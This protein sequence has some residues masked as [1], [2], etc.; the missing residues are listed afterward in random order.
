MPGNVE[1]G[2]QVER[3]D[4]QGSSRFTGWRRSAR[5]L[6]DEARS[7]PARWISFVVVAVASAAFAVWLLDLSRQHW[8]VADEFDYFSSGQEYLA[9]GREPL[10]FWLLQPHGEHTIVFTK[11]WFWILPDFVGYGHYEFYLLPSVLAHLVVVA[12][13]YRLTWI[14]TASRVLATGTALVSLAMGAGV[15]TLTYAGQ[16][17]YVGSVAAGLVVVLLAVQSSGRRALVALIALS[18]LGTLNGT[19][20]VFFAV[21]ASIVY[22]RRR[23]WPEAFAVA[24]IAVGWELTSRLVWAPHDPYQAQGLVQI[25][26]EGPAFAYAILDQAISQTLG[27]THLS[28]VVLAALVLGT[29]GLISASPGSRRTALSGWIVGTLAVAAIL[30]MLGLVV[31]RLSAPLPLVTGGGYS[32]LFLVSFLPISGILLGH[33]ARSRAASL[34]VLGVFLTISLVGVNTTSDYSSSLA[35]WKVHGEHVMQTAAAELNGGMMTFPDQAP[36]PD[37]APTVSQEQ[38][39]SLVASGRMDAVIVGEVEADQ[40]SLNMQWRLVSIGG[41]TGVC[42]DLSP[43][44]SFTVPVGGSVTILRLGSGAAV[45]LQ[46]DGSGA[47]RR[48]ELPS[49]AASLQTLSQ[50]PAVGTVQTASARV[51]LPG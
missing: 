8:F 47:I 16:F 20:F 11:L 44:Q 32:Y 45:D 25:L 51:C 22:V 30:T 5:S 1:A 2:Q 38:L 6:L 24:A 28:A 33:I 4:V 7:D 37:T 18:V 23:L 36:N 13:I 21:P 50:R 41:T 15:G 29:L 48:F 40:A 9:T 34:G 49:T 10:I 42:Q 26:R 12:A 27:D 43:G 31:G 17:Q 14:A 19:A 3:A 46:Y 35:V 39:R